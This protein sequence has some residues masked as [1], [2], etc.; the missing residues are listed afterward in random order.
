MATLRLLAVMLFLMGSIA[1]Q[2]RT[3]TGALLYDVLP[4]QP[5]VMQVQ[6]YAALERRGD[7]AA[8]P[9]RIELLRFDLVVPAELPVGVLDTLSGQRFAPAWP[10][11][12]EWLQKQTD[13]MP[14]PSSSPGRA[15]P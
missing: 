4:Y 12:V 15:G 8:I 13:I 9:A 5:T 2:T 14:R 7:R 1:S 11:W 10:R 6:A 3:P